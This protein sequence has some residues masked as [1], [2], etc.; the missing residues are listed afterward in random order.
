M[1]HEIEIVEKLCHELTHKER[2]T[3]MAIHQRY[4]STTPAGFDAIHRENYRRMME[5]QPNSLAYFVK[6]NGKAVGAALVLKKGHEHSP[7][8]I[9]D[10][11]YSMALDGRKLERIE[12]NADDRLRLST[13]ALDKLA[14]KIIETTPGAWGTVEAS[15]AN[16]GRVNFFRR[17]HWKVATE[18]NEL[19]SRVEGVHPREHFKFEKNAKGELVFSRLTSVH[20]RTQ[21]TGTHDKQITR[22]APP[23]EKYEQVLLVPAPK[24]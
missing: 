13:A 8:S 17:R 22:K 16:I 9:S 5:H 3:F 11:W 14:N 1:P 2:R 4:Y 18:E 19:L 7:K 10:R 21:I 20:L 24:K 15:P 6:I 23:V 12:A